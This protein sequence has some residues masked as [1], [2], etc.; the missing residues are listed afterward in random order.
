MNKNKRKYVRV[1]AMSTPVKKLAKNKKDFVEKVRFTPGKNPAKNKK[2][3]VGKVLP[4]KGRFIIPFKTLKCRVNVTH[5][6][7]SISP[8]M[9][10]FGQQH[11][12]ERKR[13]SNSSRK[14][15]KQYQD[16]GNQSE[17]LQYQKLSLDPVLPY[18]IIQL[19]ELRNELF[20]NKRPK[21]E[22]SCQYVNP[23]ETSDLSNY[24]KND[25]GGLKGQ[26]MLTHIMLYTFL[27]LYVIFS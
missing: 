17:K 2:V 6:S 4:P 7:C 20:G 11:S 19:K 22:S 27:I 5:K 1:P 3:F 23:E 14:L 18:T 12:V 21:V 25:K 9:Q 10:D 16:Q 26:M 13:L 15:Q 24:L 8:D